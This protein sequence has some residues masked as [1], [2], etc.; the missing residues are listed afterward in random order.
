[1]ILLPMNGSGTKD[2]LQKARFTNPLTSKTSKDA[3]LIEQENRPNSTRQS[4]KESSILLWN[5]DLPKQAPYFLVQLDAS[6]W[7]KPLPKTSKNSTLQRALGRFPGADHT[8]DMKKH[9]DWRSTLARCRATL[10]LVLWLSLSACASRVPA[11]GDSPEQQ[12]E[13][14]AVQYELTADAW[15]RLGS[16][17]QRDR[18]RRLA[19]Q[20]RQAPLQDRRSSGG[21]IEALAHALF[22]PNGG[23]GRNGQVRK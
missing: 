18:Y 23:N 14:L 13:H 16:T 5:A 11:A 9:M 22:G 12:R 10:P 7:Q 6:R 8:A 3:A 20:T 2:W 17:E 1:M 15:E 4:W 19:E 21:L